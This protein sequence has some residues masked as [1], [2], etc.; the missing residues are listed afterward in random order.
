MALV[1]KEAEPE[2]CDLALNHVR[3]DPGKPYTV[4]VMINGKPTAMEVDT[5]VGG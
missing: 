2:S 4:E 1:P 3:A 5:G